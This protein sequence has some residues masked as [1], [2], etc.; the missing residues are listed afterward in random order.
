MSCNDNA[1]IMTL[2]FSYKSQFLFYPPQRKFDK[3]YPIMTNF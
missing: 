1:N 2:Q 3:Y